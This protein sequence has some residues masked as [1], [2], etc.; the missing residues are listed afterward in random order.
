[1]LFLLSLSFTQILLHCRAG[2]ISLYYSTLHSVHRALPVY[3]SIIFAKKV[4]P[5]NFFTYIQIECTYLGKMSSQLL[6][7]DVV[8][9]FHVV[10]HIMMGINEWTWILSRFCQLSEDWLLDSRTMTHLHCIGLIHYIRCSVQ[11]SL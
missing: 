6:I 11:L 5:F 1:M 9:P 2:L 7:S 10:C 4:L 3:A 8:A